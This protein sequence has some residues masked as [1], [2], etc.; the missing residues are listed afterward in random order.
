M[1]PFFVGYTL[2]QSAYTCLNMIEFDMKED[3]MTQECYVDAFQPIAKFSGQSLL[4]LFFNQPSAIY[5]LLQH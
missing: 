2:L 5:T 3:A 1:T 4:D